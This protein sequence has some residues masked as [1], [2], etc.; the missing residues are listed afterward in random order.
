MK[1]ALIGGNV[2]G[3]QKRNIPGIF[4]NPHFWIFKNVNVFLNSGET[5]NIFGLLVRRASC[6]CQ[7]FMPTV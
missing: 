7:R 6:W 2:R 5:E 1:F 3:K 4:Q